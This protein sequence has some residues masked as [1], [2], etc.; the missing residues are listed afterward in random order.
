MIPKYM[1]NKGFFIISLSRFTRW[2]G[3]IAEDLGINIF[4]GFAGKEVLYA[5]D[6]KTITGVRTGDKGL[7]KD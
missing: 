2:L 5:E 6:Q 4:P 3:R 7:D 1:H